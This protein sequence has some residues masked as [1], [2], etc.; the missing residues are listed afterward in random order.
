MNHKRN[1]L[2]FPWKFINFNGQKYVTAVFKIDFQRE[3]V[4]RAL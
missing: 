2:T 3:N 4:V 1:A